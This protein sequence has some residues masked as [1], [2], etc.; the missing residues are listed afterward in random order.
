[1]RASSWQFLLIDQGE[2]NWNEA[3]HWLRQAMRQNPDSE[4]AR[5][6]MARLLVLRHR[7]TDAE[8]IIAE[9]VQRRPA[10]QT[11]RRLLDRLRAGLNPVAADAFDE[12]QGNGIP[13]AVDHHELPERLPRALKE[14]FRRGRLG[15]EFSR[16]L[17]ASTQRDLAGTEFIRE[18][19]RRG[20]PLAGFYSQWL[21]PKE[22][23]ECPPHAWAWNACRN[24]QESARPD[25]WH[26]LAT[27]FPEAAPETE[28]LHILAGADDN[29][30]S[31]AAGWRARYCTDSDTASRAVDVFMR[32]A[33]EQLATAEPH[34]RDELAL[35]VMACAAADA[36]EF[37]PERAA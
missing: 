8:S 4:H 24:W 3:E 5:V 14:L 31:A 21:M 12:V 34:E 1:M 37:V 28:F 35:A 33:Q 9:F 36:P 30:Q 11:A 25:C 26:H 19:T 22:T 16:A 27:R 13:A 23:P 10:S 20:D 7:P 18:E 29:N 6:V 17:I 15:S 2:A 32:E